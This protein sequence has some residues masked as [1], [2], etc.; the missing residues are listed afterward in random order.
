VMPFVMSFVMFSIMFAG[1]G[2]FFVVKSKRGMM[3]GTLVR[4][5]GFRF[6]TIRGAAF[7][8][9]GGF[10]VGELGNFGV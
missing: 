3:L 4:G 6:G 9:L 1:V 8:D 7:F 5:I 10:V 2:M